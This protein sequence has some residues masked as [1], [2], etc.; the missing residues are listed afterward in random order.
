MISFPPN[1]SL[2]DSYN[3][4]RIRFVFDSNGWTTTG[5]PFLY[6]NEQGAISF[7][8][9][10][11][12]GDSGQSIISRDSDRAPI[13][14]QMVNLVDSQNIA[15]VKHFTDQLNTAD[16]VRIG[17][18]LQVL[19]AA[20]LQITG[21]LTRGGDTVFA[22]SYATH[23]LTSTTSF[24]KLFGTDVSANGKVVL[25]IGLWRFYICASINGMSAT[26]GNAAI[27]LTAETATVV[28]YRIVVRGADT[29]S[30][31]ADASFGSST[32]VLTT[33]TPNSVVAT[34]SQSLVVEVEGWINVTVG[35]TVIPQIALTT[36]AAAS[37][38]PN[39]IFY[40]ERVAG[41]STNIKGSW[42]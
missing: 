20:G 13:F 18:G 15:G 16:A 27:S 17:G 42:T 24:Q 26:S 40:A 36:A 1:P 37:V 22:R 11:T 38:T 35:G 28:G 7:D 12:F 33:P 34:I 32:G 30:S 23:N 25:G 19:G 41:N 14:Q 39:S 6:V 3:F 31:P 21:F 10:L 8:G 2:G 5:Q 9:G 4:E 29:A